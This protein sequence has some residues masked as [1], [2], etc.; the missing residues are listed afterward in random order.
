MLRASILLKVT[1]HNLSSITFFLTLRVFFL[2][3]LN[4]SIPHAITPYVSRAIRTV[5]ER[6]RDRPERIQSLLADLIAAPDPLWYQ[7]K[8]EAQEALRVEVRV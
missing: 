5:Y 6:S 4:L 1:R 3:L 8:L 2:N 7:V